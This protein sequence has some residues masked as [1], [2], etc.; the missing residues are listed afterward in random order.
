MERERR[1]REVWRR[2]AEKIC[3][4]GFDIEPSAGLPWNAWCVSESGLASFR[5][6]AWW[7]FLREFKEALEQEG[8]TETEE[9]KWASTKLKEIE[10]A[11]REVMG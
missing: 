3:G 5:A 8:L 11:W 2:V 1:V 10:E 9:F 6:G 7:Q 4:A